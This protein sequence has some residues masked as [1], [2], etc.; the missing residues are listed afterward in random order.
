MKLTVALLLALGANVSNL[1]CSDGNLGSG[2]GSAGTTG[3][4]GTAGGAGGQGGS[5]LRCAFAEKYVWKD[6]YVSRFGEQTASSS[7][8]TTLSPPASFGFDGTSTSNL[9]ST[10]SHCSAPLPACGDA[11]LIDVSDIE[12]A[13]AH[14]D[15]Q[16]VLAQPAA[17]RY[18]SLGVADLPDSY[19]L[20]L[21]DKVGFSGVTCLQNAT[22]IPMPSGVAALVE[23]LRALAVQQIAAP[24]CA[25]ADGG[26]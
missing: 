3:G 14:P 18:G 20:E 8:L 11:N 23:L 15:V 22:C 5:T 9:A 7:A 17:P 19:S 13:L 26:V 1:A 6:Q 10:M 24:S 12:A 4:A 16:A 21:G 25:G 2:A